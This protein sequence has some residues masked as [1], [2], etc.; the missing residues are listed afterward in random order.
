[1]E[2]GP[3]S[4]PEMT[5]SPTLTMQATQAGIILGTAAY[6]SPEQARG[7]SVDKRSD[8]FAFGALLYEML[9]GKRAF[10]G[11]DVSLTL[12]KVLEREPVWE[13]LS[14]E[15]SHTVRHLLSRCLHKDIS[16]RL[17]AIGEARIT[18]QEY[19][20][21]PAAVAGVEPQTTTS[22]PW[23]R[24]LPWAV[25]V[26]I[27]AGLQ[28]GVIVLLAVL[29]TAE[30]PE[31]PLRNSTWQRK[32]PWSRW[33][34]PTEQASPFG[35]ITPFGYE[36]LARWHQNSWKAPK[37]AATISGPRTAALWV[38]WSPTDFGG[39]QRQKAALK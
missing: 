15:V 8:I 16:L 32:E 23:K 28:I 10:G 13:D 35:G 31:P 14:E 24:W 7:K 18:I 25:A 27:I 20:A 30:P 6:M 5:H 2:E 21:N 19:L 33:F 17:Q 39:S 34:H 9:T 4:S 1:M 22:Q 26:P 3:T 38:L 36:D 37:E 12:A 11:D 29:L